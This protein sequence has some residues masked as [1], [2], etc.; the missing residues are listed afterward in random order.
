MTFSSF[1]PL[2]ILFITAGAV[3]FIIAASM[4]NLS[5]EFFTYYLSLVLLSVNFSDTAG[6][7]TPTDL[8]LS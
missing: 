2:N 8:N 5:S 3:V 1:F 6:F 4:H 7:T